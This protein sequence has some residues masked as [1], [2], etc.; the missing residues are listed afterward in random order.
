MRKAKVALVSPDAT[1][2]AA[3]G[4]FGVGPDRELLE[5]GDGPDL[6]RDAAAARPALLLLQAPLVA[7]DLAGVCRSLRSDPALAE[8][9]IAI[10][11]GD[12]VVESRP[13][14]SLAD[15]F[16][17]LPPRAEEFQ[18]LLD[19][20]ARSRSV[21]LLVDDSRV[22]RAVTGA[23]LREEGGYEVVEADN[24]RSALDRLAAEPI[25]A[26]LTD[27]E[28]PEMDGFALCAE[29]KRRE[30]SRLIPVVI[31][32]S[33]ESS[34]EIEK[35]FQSGADDYLVKPAIPS[36][37]LARLAKMFDRTHRG[38]RE[39]ILVVEDSRVVRTMVQLSLEE[40]GFAVA[41]AENGR[42]AVALLEAFRPHL[43]LTDYEMPE[44][45][46]VELAHEIRR[47]SDLADIPILML[48]ARDG[49]SEE[50]RA[51]SAGVDSFVEKPFT[52]EKVIVIVEKLLADQRLKRERE[53]AR[54]YLS[55][56]AQ[57]SLRRRA[58]SGA[59]DGAPLESQEVFRTV[60]FA[61]IVGFTARSEGMAP[62][63]VVAMLN[64]FLERMTG[65]LK[66]HEAQIDKFMGDAILA[67]FDRR[68]DGALRAVRAARAMV[69]DLAPFHR[70]TGYGLAIRVGIHSGLVVEGAIGSRLFRVDY[71][72]IGD[73]VN[74]AQRLETAARPNDVIISAA[75]YECVRGAVEVEPAG[76]FALKGKKEPVEAFRV[77]RVAPG[78]AAPSR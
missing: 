63:E 2:R 54:L 57:Q 3:L 22:A 71:T 14:A 67:I 13:L 66:E 29:V 62:A 46:G 15:A 44:M 48:T 30:E 21:V 25:D 1:V 78:I 17:R 20:N 75:T 23:I 52:N 68:E 37:L 28:M 55:D 59:P 53:A 43:V 58:T 49:R 72:V 41:S 70:E 33:L 74:T 19:R 39:R 35:G 24:G 47:R 69:D 7:G 64:A 9:K 40:Q 65:I 6:L 4:G 10:L 27:V 61:D 18:E 8:T 26:V 31:L 50:I 60:L 32:S 5:W 16:L 36:I 11:T 51:S 56:G 38:Q 42:A 73:N 77:L 76:P 45:N 34:A 12:P